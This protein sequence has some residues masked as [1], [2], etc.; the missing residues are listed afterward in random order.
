[1]KTLAIIPARA[2]S[3][4]I[5]GK[6]KKLLAG[7]PLIAYTFE[8]AKLSK[9]ISKIV[10][11]SDDKDIIELAEKFDFTIIKRPKELAEDNTPMTAVVEHVIKTLKCEKEYDSI[12]LLQPTSPFRKVEDIDNCLELLKENPECDG[13]VSITES[14]EHPALAKKISSEGYLVDFC[15]PETDENRQGLGKSYRRNGAIFLVRMPYFIKNKLIKKGRLLPYL[16]PKLRSI[17]INNEIDFLLAEL[18][19][20]KI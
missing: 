14:T 16:M 13:V 11:T 20:K 4:S 5:K 6:N 1:M 10:V 9:K 17:D 3:K 12:L 18:I 2:G 8:T 7:K 19:I 15:L